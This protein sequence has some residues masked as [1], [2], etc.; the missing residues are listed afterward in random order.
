MSTLEE[1]LTNMYD[2][3]KKHGREEV[4]LAIKLALLKLEESDD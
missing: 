1:N 4:I 3:G 2:L